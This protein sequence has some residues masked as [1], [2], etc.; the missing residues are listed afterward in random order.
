M[1]LIDLKMKCKY[2]FALHILFHL[3]VDDATQASNLYHHQTMN[4]D[5][6]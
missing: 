1:S 3:H 2:T 6:P 4:D 5:H